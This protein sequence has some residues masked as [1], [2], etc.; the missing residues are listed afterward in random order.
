[1]LLASGAA[2]VLAATGCGDEDFANDPRP[3]SAVE[4]NGVITDS[5]VMISPTREGAGP[6]QLTID[7]QTDRA[8]TVT[9]EGDEIVERVG[10][11]QPKDTAKI[12]KTLPSGTYTISAGSSRAV[13][14]EDQ[15]PPATLTIG[16]ERA[17]SGTE[18]LLP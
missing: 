1:M 18:L 12:Q 11:V 9:L 2:L 5:G 15:I 3:P 17:S 16:P 4:L 6:I 14:I 13:D 10:P 8:H 7:N